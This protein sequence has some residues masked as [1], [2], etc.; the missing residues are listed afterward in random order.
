MK[1]WKAIDFEGDR[2]PVGFTARQL[3]NPEEG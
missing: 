2:Q 1:G 3:S